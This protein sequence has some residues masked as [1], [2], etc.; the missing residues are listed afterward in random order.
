MGNFVMEKGVRHKS[1]END[2][3]LR[4]HGSVLRPI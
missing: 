4:F 2:D 3:S 1:K